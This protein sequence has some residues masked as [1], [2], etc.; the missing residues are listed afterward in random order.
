VSL[1]GERGPELAE[2]PRG[3]RIYSA[4]QSATMMSG[5][6]DGGDLGTL[7]VVVRSEAGEVI[8]QKLATLK[9]TKRAGRPLAFEFV[10]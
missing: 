10:S 3:T 6:T 2:F 9:R 4:D 8:E 7:T 1:V 5:G